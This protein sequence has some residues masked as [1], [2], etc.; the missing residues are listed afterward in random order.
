MDEKGHRLAMATNVRGTKLH[1]QTVQEQGLRLHP[2]TDQASEVSSSTTL[3]GKCHMETVRRVSWHPVLCLCPS[4]VH[5][6]SMKHLPPCS[7]GPPCL[8]QVTALPL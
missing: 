8:T 7:D 6:C 5:A 2:Q 1:Q 4:S 3:A